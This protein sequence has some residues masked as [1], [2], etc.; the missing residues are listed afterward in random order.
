[1]LYQTHAVKVGLSSH[2]LAGGDARLRCG[3]RL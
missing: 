1:M 3:R 2:G